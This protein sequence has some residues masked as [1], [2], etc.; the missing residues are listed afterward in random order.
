ML[1]Q[2]SAVERSQEVPLAICKRRH[3][4]GQ[5][6]AS[7]AI[8]GRQSSSLGN[9]SRQSYPYLRTGRNNG[10]RPTM[11]L[12]RADCYPLVRSSPPQHPGWY[13]PLQSV[14]Q[15]LFIGMGVALDMR[16]PKS[17]PSFI[18]PGPELVAGPVH[19]QAS[20]WR[21]RLV[22][23]DPGAAV[24]PSSGTVKLGNS[25]W[26]ASAA[27]CSWCAWAA[28]VAAAAPACTEVT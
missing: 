6:L 26:R 19:G 11:P 20:G 23:P 7:T 9:S 18:A 17:A 27:A 15:A 16:R 5:S 1:E 14:E 4:I 2:H 10:S 13:S 28:T 21:V 22:A 24:A 3:S 25:R 8:E 12:L